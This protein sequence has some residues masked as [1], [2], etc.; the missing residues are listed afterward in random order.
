MEAL[1][2][3][4]PSPWLVR[5]L[6]NDLDGLTKGDVNG[7]IQ[8]ARITLDFPVQELPRSARGAGPREVA[9]PEVAP[10]TRGRRVP[11]AVDVAA[12]T[13]KQLV[14]GGLIDPPLALTKTYKG[15]E[16]SARIEADGRVACLGET[17]D[18]VSLAA[19]MA[20][21]SVIGAPSGHKYP[22]TN[23]WS[24]WRFRDS[25]GQLRKLTVLRERLIQKAESAT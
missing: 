7:A 10:P 24:F 8:R 17:Y 25:D 16:L 2:D 23:G 18:S 3:P 5:R 19:G 20:R 15:R 6:A 21:R 1:F 4:E 12:V 22:P 13:V 14:E 11:V 9:P